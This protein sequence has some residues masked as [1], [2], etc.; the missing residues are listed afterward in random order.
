[1]V[2]TAIRARKLRYLY[3]EVEASQELCS[4]EL[5]ESKHLTLLT[6]KS[7]V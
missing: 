1:M 6:A 2:T 4:A 7:A 5:N 3:T